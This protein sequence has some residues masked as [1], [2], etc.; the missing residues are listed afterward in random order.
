MFR[1]VKRVFPLLATIVCSGC[2]IEPET[3][4]KLQE[5]VKASTVQPD[6]LEPDAPLPKP[7]KLLFPRPTE[8]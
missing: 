4:A 5:A 6:D 2:G 1:S 3:I 7:W 8:S